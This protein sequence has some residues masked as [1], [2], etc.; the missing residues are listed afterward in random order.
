MKIPEE[1]DFLVYKRHLPHWRMRESIYFVTFC[2]K[3]ISL[4]FEEQK[5]VLNNIIQGN[6]K[7]YDLIAA[8][9][10]IDHCHILF[11]PN[12]DFSLSKIMKGIK[13]TTA[14]NINKIRKSQGSVWQAEY[15][16][17]IIRDEKELFDKIKYMWNNPI[18]EGLTEDTSDYHGWYFNDGFFS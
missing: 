7:Y 8:I 5:L 15:Y 13:G 2:T 17:R 18:K 1:D 16:D 12:K 10:L 9:I 14:Y 3:K 11:K 4:S 6:G